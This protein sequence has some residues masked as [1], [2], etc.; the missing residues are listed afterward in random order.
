MRR[1][2]SARWN[3]AVSSQLRREIRDLWD[4]NERYFLRRDPGDVGAAAEQGLVPA[5][6]LR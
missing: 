2:F 6:H 1:F 3:A 5:T 4:N